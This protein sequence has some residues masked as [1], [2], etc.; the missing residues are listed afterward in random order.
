[1]AMHGVV[2]GAH[3]AV[4]A[5]LEP[6]R[7]G[8]AERRKRCR[9]HLLQLVH[10][11]RQPPR[12]PV[13]AA[14]ARALPRHSAGRR[15]DAGRRSGRRVAVGGG[16][17]PPGPRLARSRRAAPPRPPRPWPRRPPAAAPAPAAARR[18]ALRRPAGERE[19]ALGGPSVRGWAQ[20]GAPCRREQA[21]GR[22]TRSRSKTRTATAEAPR[23]S[24]SARQDLP[25]P[26]GP[27]GST[28]ARARRTSEQSAEAA[29]GVPGSVSNERKAF[30]ADGEAKP[31]VSTAPRH[32]VVAAV[33]KGGARLEGEAAGAEEPRE[34]AA[35]RRRVAGVVDHP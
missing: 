8:L 4:G 29:Y 34:V 9:L 10:H 15:G 22:R 5:G 35:E 26:H 24:A 28:S 16:A 19:H 13:A 21:E 27:T 3:E 31:L 1:M 6:L 32:H 30:R 20:L 33:A 11:R 2:A 7:A 17:A 12:P 18:G 14:A 23:C 25:A